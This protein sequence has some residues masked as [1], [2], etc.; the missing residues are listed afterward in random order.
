M[1]ESGAMSGILALV[2]IGVI[3]IA[4]VMRR[5]APQWGQRLQLAG[6][7]QHVGLLSL[8]PQCS[9]ALVRIGQETLVLGLTPHAITLLTKTSEHGTPEKR[10]Q[11]EQSVRGANDKEERTNVL[12]EN[13]EA[14]G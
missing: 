10:R 6:R 1:S 11:E 4:V 8:T 7:L 12:S 2:L 13:I 3:G 5:F 9:V 14:T